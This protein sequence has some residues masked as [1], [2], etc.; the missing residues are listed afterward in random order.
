MEQLIQFFGRFHPLLVHLPIGILMV[1]VLFDWLSK[2]KRYQN[3]SPSVGL[4]YLL[5]GVGAIFSCL[6]GYF[7]S[8]SGEYEGATLQQHQWLGIATA[9]GALGMYA[10]KTWTSKARYS[11]AL[12]AALMLLLTGAGH[13]GGSLTHGE[14]YLV[15]AMPEPFRSW[16][17][18][19]EA[20]D[21][22]VII[23]NVQEAMVYQDIVVPILKEKCYNCHNDS[24]QKG[25]LRMDSPEFLAKG[26]KS[27]AI[28]IKAGFPQ[29]S[30]LIR[31]LLLP[32]NDEKHMPPKEKPQ[33]TENE[34]QLL[35]WWIEQGADYQHPVKMLAQSESIRPILL[36]LTSA[37]GE[38]KE[39]TAIYPA[40]HLK[41]PDANAIAALRANRVVVLPIGQ[42]ENLLSV[43]FVNVEA[44]DDQLL[45]SLEDL[46]EHIVWLKWSYSKVSDQQLA[47]LEKMTNLTKL[48]LN[49]TN[50]T[51]EG[52]KY[53]T[54][55]PNLKYLNLVGTKVTA[56]GVRTLAQLP[57]LRQLY[58]YQTLISTQEGKSLM[59]QFP[60]TTI[61]TG[62]Y[63]MP[64]ALADS[65]L[66]GE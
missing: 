61:D 8:Q 62:G 22:I 9:T 10:Y 1:A 13:L 21:D 51:D 38:A 31:R 18:V 53:L 27:K 54:N 50:I 23:K 44:I 25:K 60:N 49:N 48:Y 36:G 46:K 58:L 34:I 30:E 39:A 41:A 28:M 4:L 32:K 42:Q 65:M 59:A 11:L 3:L 66:V 20:K 2:L 63:R 19:E 57:N 56:Q 35:Q 15:A 16:M 64:I 55:L 52:L 40:I 24:K 7:L 45:A 17:G 12:S 14:D 37:S 26:G 29:E 33:L 5:G 43:N 6:T 47:V